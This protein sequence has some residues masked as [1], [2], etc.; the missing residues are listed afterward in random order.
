MNNSSQQDHESYYHEPS[1]SVKPEIFIACSLIL[2]ITSFNLIIIFLFIRMNRKRTKIKISDLL[3]FSLSLSD[4]FVGIFSISFEL[5]AHIWPEW[6]LGNF[7]CSLASLN[8]YSQYTCSFLGL[9]LLSIHRFMQ[10]KF[11]LKTNENVTKLKLFFIATTWLV[12]YGY[13]AICVIVKIIRNEFD[14]YFCTPN[15]SQ[16]LALV[17]NIILNFLPI[18][19]M[20]AFNIATFISIMKSKKKRQSILAVANKK[21]SKS[22]LAM[23]HSRLASV[24]SIQEVSI[25][26]KQRMSTI[27]EIEEFND[28]SN[29]I[30]K[31][32]L[33]K[34]FNK[35]LKSSLTALFKTRKAITKEI[36]ASICIWMIILNLLLTQSIYLFSWLYS[37]FC[38]GCLN[39]YINIIGYWMNYIFS[40]IN[41]LILIIF[42]EGFRKEFH[43][44][45]CC[46]T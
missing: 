13:Y 19:L 33:A 44:L 36:K 22:T 15:Y 37:M 28:L 24:Q 27:K 41:P 5:S 3:F 9:L 7:L 25:N 26:N 31:I 17:S 10:L 6:P 21:H 46:K 45:F 42:H 1:Q 8:V 20:I 11:P 14:F 38:R 16:I 30:V 39:F 29:A 35:N 23:N 40:A 32:S 43:K 4:L 12:P 18:F 2:I 34:S